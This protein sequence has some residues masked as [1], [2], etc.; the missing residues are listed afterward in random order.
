MIFALPYVFPESE[1]TLLIQIMDIGAC[2]GV[3]GARMFLLER[4]ADLEI[5]PVYHGHGIC[6]WA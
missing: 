5:S 6:L 3:F 4:N 2:L 1:Y